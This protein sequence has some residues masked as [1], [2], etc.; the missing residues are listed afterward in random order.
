[1]AKYNKQIIERICSLFE[2]DSYTIAEVCK[3]VGISERIYYTWM[4]NAEFAA[5]IKKAKDRFDA[6]MVREAKN[7]LMKLVRGFEVEEVTTEYLPGKDGAENAKPKIRAQKRVRKHFAPNV[8][9]TIFLLVNKAPD[10]FQNRQN[11]EVTGKNGEPLMQ[12]ARIL[13]KKEA[14]DLLR[15]LDE[16]C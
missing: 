4:E 10:E 15:Q 5:A 1:M 6:T 9:A 12:P 13:T 14:K 11:N 3:E 2:A 16:E 7:S 8:A